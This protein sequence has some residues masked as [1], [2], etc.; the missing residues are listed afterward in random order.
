MQLLEDA[1]DAN[2]PGLDVRL[3]FI[4]NKVSANVTLV[5]E[6]ATVIISSPV[7][8]KGNQNAVIEVRAFRANTDLFNRGRYEW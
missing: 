7:I 1:A 8:A 4:H 2:H 5:V 3:I 6:P